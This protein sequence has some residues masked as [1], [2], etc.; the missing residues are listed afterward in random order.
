MMPLV[1]DRVATIG[2]AIIAIAGAIA[3]VA[4]AIKTIEETCEARRKREAER[5]NDSVKCASTSVES[6]E[7]QRSGHQRIAGRRA[8]TAQSPP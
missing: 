2:N 6:G 4:T 3:A 1:W 8:R 7:S 5:V